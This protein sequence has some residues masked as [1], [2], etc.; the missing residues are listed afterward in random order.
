MKYVLFCVVLL[1]TIVWAVK[2]EVPPLDEW[3][4]NIGG[5]YYENVILWPDGEII[6]EDRGF[7]LTVMRVVNEYMRWIIWPI[8]FGILIYFGFEIITS[9]DPSA[10]TKEK[11]KSIWKIIVG[12]M[13]IILVYTAIRFVVNLY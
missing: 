6:T 3:Q 7:V 10:K 5:S 11:L 9:D 8:L 2:V 12:I 13:I 4:G 1:S